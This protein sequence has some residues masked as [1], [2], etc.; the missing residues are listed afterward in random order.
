[1]KKEY[2][3]DNFQRLCRKAQELIW[4]NLCGEKPF[5]FYVFGID[6]ATTRMTPIE[7]IFFI[8]SNVHYVETTKENLYLDTQ[9]EVYAN[10]RRYVADFMLKSY[11][12]DKDCKY[13]L[14]KP[15][16]IELDGKDYH[17]T[18]EQRE[19]DYNR[20]NDLK[21]A[22]YEV[23]RFT[24]KQVYNKPLECIAKVCEYLEKAEKVVKQ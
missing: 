9:V 6:D 21:V 13:I 8:A 11:G 5:F 10:K 4:N 22:G 16:I 1:M 18:L 12:V 15:L 24:G 3:F 17:R 20:E 2:A 23:M 19:Y 7:Q 14:K